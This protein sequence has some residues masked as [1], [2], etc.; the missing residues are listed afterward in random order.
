VRSKKIQMMLC[1]WR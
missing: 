1:C